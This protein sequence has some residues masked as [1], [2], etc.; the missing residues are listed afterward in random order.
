MVVKQS[1]VAFEISIVVK[2]SSVAAVA[3][4]I[5]T[6]TE[7]FAAR[8]AMARARASGVAMTMRRRVVRISLIIVMTCDADV[9]VPRE[10]HVSIKVGYKATR[11]AVAIVTL[12]AV[13][14]TIA[15]STERTCVSARR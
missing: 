10:D 12:R 2:K 15:M 9:S 8:V 3:T 5:A 14:S 7:R 1:F 13:A 11:T 6:T 4:S